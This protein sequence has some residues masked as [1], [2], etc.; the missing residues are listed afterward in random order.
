MRQ[1]GRANDELRKIKITRNYLK[2][3]E[4]SCLIEMGNTKVVC[5]ASVENGVPPFLRNTGQGW[6]T[7][8]YGMLPR[9]THSRMRRESANGKQTG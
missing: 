7:A 2:F 5:S 9:A 8:E 6:V 4:G 3:A 1:N